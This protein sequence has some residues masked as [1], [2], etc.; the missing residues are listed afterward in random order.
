MVKNIEISKRLLLASL[1]A[2]FFVK[3]VYAQNAKKLKLVGRGQ[4]NMFGLKIFDAELYSFSGI[5]NPEDSFS[6]KLTYLRNFSAKEISKSAISEI[7]AQGYKNKVQLEKWREKMNAIFPNVK[8]NSYI[9][10]HKDEK[11]AAIFYYN[12][13][14][15]GK[16]DDKAFSKVFFDIWLGK[17]SSQPKLRD[18]LINHNNR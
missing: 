3:P 17:N 18:K 9:I 15:I 12:G 10:G 11:G 16:I 14:Y 6:L 2:S 4:L 1:F 8:K 7:E 5:Y 13:N